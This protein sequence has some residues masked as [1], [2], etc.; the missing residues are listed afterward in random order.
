M[1][2]NINPTP[3]PVATPTPTVEE[4]MGIVKELQSKLAGTEGVVTPVAPVAPVTTPEQLSKLEE[5]RLKKEK[6]NVF[7]DAVKVAE[8]NQRNKESLA[9]LAEEISTEALEHFNSYQEDCY[10][11]GHELGLT[12]KHVTTDLASMFFEEKENIEYVPAIYKEQVKTFINTPIKDR[13]DLAEAL[14]PVIRI[15]LEGKQKEAVAVA[16]NGGYD[17]D[18]E[19]SPF[20]EMLAERNRRLLKG[21]V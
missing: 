7:Q 20:Q 14:V 9:K 3:E 1:T 8:A 15:A 11:K 17:K 5:F 18:G 4:L 21:G 19:M 16:R 10:N 13:K 12:N 2:D 6:E